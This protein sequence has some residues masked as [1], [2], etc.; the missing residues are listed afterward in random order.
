MFAQRFARCYG[1]LAIP[2]ACHL[3]R[4]VVFAN[5]CE[6]FCLT[7]YCSWKGLLRIPR[8]GRQHVC[9]FVCFFAVLLELLP[10]EPA[11][12]WVQLFGLFARAVV[13]II[14]TQQLTLVQLF[15]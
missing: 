8:V 12:S 2:N 11:G 1:Q 10:T 6:G 9:L 14:Y 3:C 15:V 7:W 13:N 5:A 4:H